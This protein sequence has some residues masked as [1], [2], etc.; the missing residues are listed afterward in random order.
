MEE[1]RFLD[2]PGVVF[3]AQRTRCPLN[4]SGCDEIH[5]LISVNPGE[6]P[7][8]ISK[9][10]SGGELSRIMLAIKTVLSGKGSTDTMIFDEV[11]TGISG[12]AA[13]K[14]GQKLKETAR[15]AQV[16][17]VTHLAQIAAMADAHFRIQKEVHDG[18][19]FTHVTPL[20]FEERTQELARIMGG[21]EITPLM[22][23]NAAEMI[24]R[25]KKL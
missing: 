10:A 21:S 2:M 9:I 22:L 8:P 13:Q 4:A 11:D 14:V 3:Q 19:T 20:S 23:K 5:F 6:T 18:K 25:G 12:S 17:C 15:S 7:K 1:L 24:Q 16:L